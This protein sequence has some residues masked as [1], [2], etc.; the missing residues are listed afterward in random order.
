[1]QLVFVDKEKEGLK[2]NIKKAITI[3]KKKI[4]KN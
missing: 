2:V 3:F 1:M 4:V